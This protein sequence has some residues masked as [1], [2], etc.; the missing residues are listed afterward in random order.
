MA[1]SLDSL[2]YQK[3]TDL[4]ITMRSVRDH[5]SLHTWTD[6]YCHS[7]GDDEK[8]WFELL[9][10]L[11]L[12]SEQPLQHYVGYLNGQPAVCA[13]LFL[14]VG[15][16]GLFNVATLPDFRHRG[17]GRAITLHALVDAQKRGYRISVLGSSEMAHS[18][19]AKCG[20]VDHGEL[21]A[22][23]FQETSA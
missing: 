21:L 11:E 18:L 6:I 4:S 3:A 14:G 10:G 8:A 5:E 22:Y 13:S 15:V 16:A 1:C 17:L 2:P 12:T 7:H 23:L 19:Y 9:S 20:F